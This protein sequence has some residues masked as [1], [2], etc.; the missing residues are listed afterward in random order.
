MSY[1][2][3]HVFFCT[4]ARKDGRDCCQRFDAQ[5]MRD[6]A[7][8]RSKELG[9]AGKGGVRIN[10]AGCLDR[11]QEGPVIVIYPEEIWYCYLDKEDIDEILQAHLIDG[12]P[13]ERLKI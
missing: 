8:K 1:Y 11:C 7:K 5:E 3:H 4:N 10:S 6:Y 12:H 13:V 9:I 2:K